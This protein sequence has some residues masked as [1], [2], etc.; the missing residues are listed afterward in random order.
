MGQGGFPVLEVEWERLAPGGYKH[1]RPWV[2]AGL[3]VKWA[4]WGPGP[5]ASVCAHQPVHPRSLWV[6]PD[7]QIL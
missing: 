6:N 4:G 1:I 3:Q 7:Y 5:A 2:Q